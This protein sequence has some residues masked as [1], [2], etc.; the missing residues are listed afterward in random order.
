MNPGAILTPG[1][2]A[3]QLTHGL[4]GV[5]QALAQ[6]GQIQRQDR[7]QEFQNNQSELRMALAQSADE[8]ASAAQALQQA[9]FEASH[10]QRANQ[11]EQNLGIQKQQ[12]ANQEMNAQRQD[13]YANPE[14]YTASP[15]PAMSGTAQ[16]LSDRN[17][18]K[19][20]AQGYVRPEENRIM[21]G[22]DWTHP[23]APETPAFGP[24]LGSPAAQGLD[25]FNQ[26]M[27][28]KQTAHLSLADQLALIN[29][30]GGV[31]KEVATIRNEGTAANTEKKITSAEGIAED[32]RMDA[33]GKAFDRKLE[34]WTSDRQAARDTERWDK[35]TPD[36]QRA[37]DNKYL[38]DNP[39]PKSNSSGQ[40]KAFDENKAAAGVSQ[41]I[42][43]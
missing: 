17:T 5:A 15:S 27:R 16:R 6:R 8:R 31:Q 42:H 35:L 37:W 4:S 3:D 12:L 36:A 11:F 2:I 9:Q 38:M 40:P 32:K 20:A 43:P 14:A 33:Q 34:K 25:V 18:F 24:K 10:R 22:T 30:R 19:E 1:G 7:Q 28:S 23:L 13:M 29:A 39:K 26:R 21:S 41:F